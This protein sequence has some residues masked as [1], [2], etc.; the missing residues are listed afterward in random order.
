MLVVAP[1]RPT[2]MGK[3]G[4]E[5]EMAVRFLAHVARGF[6]HPGGIIGRIAQALCEPAHV[7]SRCNSAHRGSRRRCGQGVRVHELDYVR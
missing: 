4:R 2:E 5:I 3:G 7:R 6:R 1:A